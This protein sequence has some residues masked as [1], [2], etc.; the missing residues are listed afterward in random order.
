MN[1]SY[2]TFPALL[3]WLVSLQVMAASC[4]DPRPLRFALIPKT[5]AEAQLAQY[6]PLIQQLEKA[7]ERR[8][9]VIPTPSYGTVIEGLLAGGIDLAEVGPASYAIA[10]NRGA[11]IT[12]F[13]TFSLR[14]G[15]H[16][17]SASAYRSL[18]IVRR[19]KGLKKIEQ[20]RGKTL[21]LTDPASTSGA[22]LPRQ[23]ISQMTGTLL[24]SYFQRVTFA[25]SHDRAID[26]V[27]KGLVDAAFVSS[28][29]LDEAL[30]R[31]KIRPDE[32]SVLWK[33]S[34]IPYDPIVLNQRLCPELASRIKKVFLGDT[35]PL[36]AMFRELDMNGFVPASDEQY[37][38]IRELFATRP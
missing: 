17:D 6:R 8:I 36:E 18:L 37:R 5:N 13:A 11:K 16:T 27:Q 20:L 38:E 29:R 24:E 1:K 31:G 3:L 4:D 14:K 35:S 22:L 2:A 33:S 28:T 23:A 25:G 15:T 30:R 10:M 12:T 32:I 21:S 19:D 7:L 34:P 26:A 9:A